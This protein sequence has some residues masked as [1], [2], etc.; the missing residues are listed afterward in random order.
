MRRLSGTKPGQL[1]RGNFP[2]RLILGLAITAVAMVA[3]DR[4]PGSAQP[5]VAFDP[6]PGTRVLT[7]DYGFYRHPIWAPDDSTIAV[8]WSPSFGDAPQPSA[9]GDVLLIDA[10]T[11]EQ[12]VLDVGPDLKQGLAREAMF[13]IDGGKGLGFYYFE[14]F[15]D[16][17]RPYLVVV[18]LATNKHRTIEL[19][20]CWPLAL[21]RNG[22]KLLVHGGS[23][24]VFELSWFDISS[25]DIR[26]ELSLPRSN[27]REHRYT[28]FSL[29]PDESKLLMG[30]LQGTIVQ[31]EMGSGEAP[32]AFLSNAVTPAWSAD[33]SKIAYALIG[34]PSDYYFGQLVVANADGSS[35]TPLFAEPQQHGMLAP[36][37]SPDGSQIAFLYQYGAA[38]ANSLLIAS[39][40]ENLRPASAAP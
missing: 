16:Q 4:I 18:D 5:S 8:L 11:G 34:S 12:H 17:Q 40:P 13:W 2:H 24:E 33:G 36:A 30:D 9:E 15:S 6:V 29:S 1:L 26:P 27:P 38:N 28:D 22:T 32:A 35:P 37:W 14:F 21:G 3:C 25:G 39:V 7:Q 10:E 31:Y 23:D 20:Q 19:C